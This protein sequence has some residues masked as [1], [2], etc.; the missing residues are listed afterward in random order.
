MMKGLWNS[1]ISL[2]TVNVNFKNHI[3]IF[4]EA[5]FFNHQPLGGTVDWLLARKGHQDVTAGLTH[6]LDPRQLEAPHPLPCA[7]N[8]R[9]FA[10]PTLSCPRTHPWGRNVVMRPS[11]LGMGLNPVK[12]PC[13]RDWPH[14]GL[15][16]NFKDLV[17]GCGKTTHLAALGPLPPPSYEDWFQITPG[18]LQTKVV[19]QQGYLR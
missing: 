2:N 6:E 1:L 3:K 18:K 8:V 11:G 5:C 12:G 15:Y 7:R 9:L 10:F 19:T 16:I 14:C 17:S 13:V 4:H